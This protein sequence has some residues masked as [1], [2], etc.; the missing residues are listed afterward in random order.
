MTSEDFG[1]EAQGRCPTPPRLPTVSTAHNVDVQ[2][3]FFDNVRDVRSTVETVALVR[4]SHTLRCGSM[5]K[6]PI[7]YRIS[8]SK[9]APDFVTF[10]KGLCW[11]ETKFSDF[12]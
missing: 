4:R 1:G 3:K 2:E 6:D 11:A 10:S 5:P 8:K 7:S 9:P 12:D